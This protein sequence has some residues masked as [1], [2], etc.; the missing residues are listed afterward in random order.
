MIKNFNGW[1]SFH[2]FK[3]IWG[4]LVFSNGQIRFR[5]VLELKTLGCVGKNFIIEATP[6]TCTSVYLW[7]NRDCLVIFAFVSNHLTGHISLSEKK[8]VHFEIIKLQKLQFI[9][10]RYELFHFHILFM[11]SLNCLLIK[12]T[13]KLNQS[14]FDRWK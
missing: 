3:K 1:I 5:E 14:H 9:L 7:T 12:L 6:E 4:L 13:W 10:F 11:L 8:K 2:F